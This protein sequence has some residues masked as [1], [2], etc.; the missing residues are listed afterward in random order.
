MDQ[1]IRYTTDILSDSL[2]FKNGTFYWDKLNNNDNNDN[3]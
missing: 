3:N 1:C 2:I